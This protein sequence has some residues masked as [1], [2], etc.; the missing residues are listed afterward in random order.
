VHQGEFYVGRAA[1]PGGKGRRDETVDVIVVDWDS[2]PVAGT[3]FGSH[4]PRT[5]LVQHTPPGRGRGY[6]WT[7]VVEDIPI[8]TTTVTTGADGAAV[9]EVT[10]PSRA[11]TK[12]APPAPIHA[13]RKSAARLPVGM[14][15]WAGRV[16]AGKSSSH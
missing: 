6:Y 7:W 16:A 4:L 13:A 5:S 1:R 3:P 14:G 2:A 8:Y 12:S 15:Q 10:P 9:V 11:A